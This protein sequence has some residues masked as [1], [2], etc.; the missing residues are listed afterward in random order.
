MTN[1]GVD[2]LRA[3]GAGVRVSRNVTHSSA[4]RQG[5]GASPDDETRTQS[6]PQALEAEE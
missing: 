3:F 6:K 4:A 2:A 5:W 1:G